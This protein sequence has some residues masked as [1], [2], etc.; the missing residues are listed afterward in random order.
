MKLCKSKRIVHLLHFHALV[1]SIIYLQSSVP[2]AQATFWQQKT[3]KWQSTSND[4]KLLYFFSTGTYFCPFP[5]DV[6][7][8]ACSACIWS[9]YGVP[10]LIQPHGGLNALLTITQLNPKRFFV[11]NDEL[12]FSGAFL[13]GK[14]VKTSDSKSTVGQSG[15]FPLSCTVGVNT[16]QLQEVGASGHDTGEQHI[17]TCVDRYFSLNQRKIKIAC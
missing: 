6:L 4:F 15:W 7:C 17:I 8:S 9:Q 10:N 14:L 5:L 2:P 1:T 12:R 3:R 13:Y 11:D 16:A